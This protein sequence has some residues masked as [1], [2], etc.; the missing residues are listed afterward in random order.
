MTDRTWNSDM[1]RWI[2]LDLESL[3]RIV[4]ARIMPEESWEDCPGLHAEHKALVGEIIELMAKEWEN[5]E[6]RYNGFQFADWL[7][8][9]GGVE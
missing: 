7:R 9:L 4:H 8:A 1:Q 6:Y 5:D 3:A 2:Y